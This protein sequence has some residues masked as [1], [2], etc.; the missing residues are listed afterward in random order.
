MAQGQHQ[1]FLAAALLILVAVVAEHNQVLVALAVQAA[2]Q[3]AHRLDRVLVQPQILVAVAVGLGLLLELV[4]EE[5]AAP[6]LSSCLIL[7]PLV[8]QLSSNPQQ[9]GKPR[10]AQ[11][12]LTTLL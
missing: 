1:L 12:R 7:C 9:H 2:V 6:V 5:Q 8:R 3:M 11:A 4:M 10:L